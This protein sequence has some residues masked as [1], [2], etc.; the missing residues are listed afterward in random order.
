MVM[1][2][3]RSASSPSTSSAKSTSSPV[4]PCLLRVALQRRQL[5][6]EDLLGVGQQP[7]DQRRLA[8]VDRA[9]GEE[10][11]QRLALLPGKIVAHA[12]GRRDA[13]WHVVAHGQKYPSRFF[14]SIEPASSRS[15]S[16]PWRSEVLAVSIS[17][18]MPSSVSASDSMAPVSG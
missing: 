6:L 11:Q 1:P 15:I 17:L 16:R 8:V 14:F 9:A 2:C 13:L 4:V 18:T 5:V 3:S 7:P 10:P 12:F